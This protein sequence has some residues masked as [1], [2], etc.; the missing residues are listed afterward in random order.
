MEIHLVLIDAGHAH[1][2][3]CIYSVWSDKK[4]AEKEAERLNNSSLH[5]GLGG[6]KAGV[7][8]IELNKSY[9]SWH[10]QS[11]SL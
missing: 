11:D 6:G 2:T 5:L 7:K 3:D 1:E 8:T 4:E 10:E 9:D